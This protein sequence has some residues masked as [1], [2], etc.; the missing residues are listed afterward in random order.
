MN[1]KFKKNFWINIK[2]L[3]PFFIKFLKSN[4]IKFFK[5]FKNKIHFDERS[6]VL[7]IGA[8]NLDDDHENVFINN[9]YFN[10]FVFLLQIE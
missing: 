6:E 10:F 7:D 4:R 1:S 9:Y 2:F 8:V 3:N 5:Y